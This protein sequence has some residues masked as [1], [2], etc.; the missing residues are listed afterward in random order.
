MKKHEREGE[1]EKKKNERKI[2]GVCMPH[3]VSWPD[4]E[5][6]HPIVLI[7]DVDDDTQLS[8]LA[9]EKVFCCCD[10]LFRLYSPIPPIS[11]FKD[12]LSLRVGDKLLRQSLSHRWTQ[13]KKATESIVPRQI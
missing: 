11:Q 1:K 12:N 13:T 2:E 9:T 5:P 3:P 10:I 4:T 7:L 6:G 8:L